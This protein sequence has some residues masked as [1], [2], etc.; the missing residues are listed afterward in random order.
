MELANG[1]RKNTNSS[2]NKLLFLPLL[3]FDGPV[4]LY[5]PLWVRANRVNSVY[6]SSSGHEVFFC[7]IYV[8]LFL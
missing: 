2:L 7:S 1:R 3:Q 6:L 5:S 8:R 4:S